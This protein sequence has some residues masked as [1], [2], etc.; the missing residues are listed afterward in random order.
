MDWVPQSHTTVVAARRPDGLGFCAELLDLRSPGISLRYLG[1]PPGML[2][3]LCCYGRGSRGGG[4]GGLRGE[5]PTLGMCYSEHVAC[6]ASQWY[7]ATTGSQHDHDIVQ[8]WDLRMCTV[9][10]SQKVCGRMGYTSLCWSTE[11]PLTVIVT[12]RAG[13]LCVYSFSDD[14]R[15]EPQDDDLHERFSGRGNADT[16]EVA[17]VHDRNARINLHS[18]LTDGGETEDDG[19]TNPSSRDA[20]SQ[21][22]LSRHD[23]QPV[24]T[25]FSWSNTERDQ[26]TIK[27]LDPNSSLPPSDHAF[28]NWGVLAECGTINDSDSDDLERGSFSF[29]HATGA[30]SVDGRAREKRRSP[31]FWSS[32][33]ANQDDTSASGPGRQKPLSSRKC[34]L[35]TRVPTAAVAWLAAASVH[36][37]SATPNAAEAGRLNRPNE[38][39]HL[40]QPSCCTDLPRLLLLNSENGELYTQVFNRKGTIISM[41]GD[42]PFAAAGPNLFAFEYI[43]RFHRTE[44]LRQEKLLCY[45][46]HHE[47]VKTFGSAPGLNSLWNVALSATE[48]HQKGV[49]GEAT[50]GTTK[51]HPPGVGSNRFADKIDQT[52]QGERHRAH[53]G[54]LHDDFSGLLDN[55]DDDDDDHDDEDGNKDALD[56]I[57]PV[58]GLGT[59]TASSST[60]SQ[61]GTTGNPCHPRLLSICGHEHYDESDYCSVDSNSTSSDKIKERRHR[62]TSYE[63]R[64]PFKAPRVPLRHMV[65]GSCAIDRNSLALGRLSIGF[66]AD[67]YKNMM[68]LLQEGIDREAYIVF[69]YGLIMAE[70][71]YGS[72]DGGQKVSPDSPAVVV[73]IS[74]AVPGFLQLLAAEREQRKRLGY[75]DIPFSA[76]DFPQTKGGASA[77][78]VAEARLSSVNV[79]TTNVPVLFVRNVVGLPGHLSSNPPLLSPMIPHMASDEGLDARQSTHEPCAAI[80]SLRELM[81]RAMGWLGWSTD[82]ASKAEAGAAV[83]KR[84]PKG[85]PTPLTLSSSVRKKQYRHDGPTSHDI[86]DDGDTTI[87]PSSKPQRGD[88]QLYFIESDGIGLSSLQETIERRVAVLVLLER[89]EEAS[90]LL[91]FYASFHQLYP[92]IALEL[93]AA[94]TE[95]SVPHASFHPRRRACGLKRQL[96]S[97]RSRTMGCT[98]WLSLALFFLDTFVRPA[99]ASGDVPASRPTNPRN[100]EDPATTRPPTANNLKSVSN[101]AR[102]LDCLEYYFLILELY[103]RLPLSDALALGVLMLLPPKYT[104]ADLDL[105]IRA[106]QILVDQQY[107]D[108]PSQ[109][110]GAVEG[111]VY[112][113]KSPVDKFLSEYSSR[114]SFL[115]TAT[116]ETI[117][118]ESTALQRYVDETAEVQ[119]PLSYITAFGETRGMTYCTWREAYRAQLNARGYGF[120]RC[121]YDLST[122]KL[123]TARGEAASYD[124]NDGLFNV[125]GERSLKL[126]LGLPGIA[127][128]AKLPVPDRA[129][130]RLMKQTFGTLRSS[131]AQVGRLPAYPS[132]QHARDPRRGVELRCNCGQPMHTTAPSI[133]PV[134]QTAQFRKHPMPCGNSECTQG[135]T[136]MC[137]VCGER[138][139]PRMTELP[140]ERS[141]VW[142]TVCLHGGHWCDMQAWFAKHTKCPVENCPCNCCDGKT[143]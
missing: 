22:H 70:H 45:L 94:G 97:V 39:R 74:Q 35:P 32:P 16:P 4:R 38:N 13:G 49:G 37:R 142:C 138:M 48:S 56:R 123:L 20:P 24:Q 130:D 108:L 44:L 19:C 127:G 81:L 122:I 121:E 14:S 137:V 51:L 73:P 113:S 106:L 79:A 68:A 60:D 109:G 112:G 120:K 47:Q 43:D 95:L 30:T 61:D 63:A 126:P 34:H 6:S 59:S 131:A 8:L 58:S 119:G 93:S 105:T 107:Y 125:S 64:Q 135:Q 118:P 9:P 132:L 55:D 98:Y 87:L 76:E 25:R 33:G 29:P 102:R 23:T 1:A 46:Q 50:G 12:T 27:F 139:E 78:G 128:L 7:V 72:A 5:V 104:T 28:C 82:S 53:L 90:E 88:V 67:P 75:A 103:P 133:G 114:C 111:L 3:T 83:K 69:R 84:E 65:G 129:L 101:E 99:R 66:L 10:L 91:A 136:P 18:A 110:S 117:T 89:F 140:P 134:T 96:A 17:T 62:G 86:S 15:N 143:L 54:I 71:L 40:I 116:V 115:L 2:G 21:R 124:A 85:F 100:E 11:E 26:G 77:G 141:F 57:M 31:F 52:G 41:F 42:V 80:G 92:N 36:S